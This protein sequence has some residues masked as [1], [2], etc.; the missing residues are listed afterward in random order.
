MIFLP[1]KLGLNLISYPFSILAIVCVTFIILGSLFYRLWKNKKQKKLKL[2]LWMFSKK[3]FSSLTSQ[4]F[5][6]E[7]FFLMKKIFL[8][9]QNKK[10]YFSSLGENLSFLVSYISCCWCRKSFLSFLLKLALQS[11]AFTKY[12]IIKINNFYLC[13]I[14][15]PNVR[16]WA[17]K[18]L[19]TIHILNFG[20]FLNSL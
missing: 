5:Q 16:H 14:E 6:G 15:N 8:N 20:I 9:F 19:W 13:L 17:K 12:K 10:K 3:L 11:D 4:W 7:I 1:P 18:M 2:N